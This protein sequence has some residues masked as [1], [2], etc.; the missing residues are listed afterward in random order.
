MYLK[1]RAY[2][3]VLLLAAFAANSQVPA[4]AGN[5]VPKTPPT[6]AIDFVTVDKNADGRLSKE[7]SAQV[8]DLGSVFATL[9]VDGDTYVTPAEFAKW[10]RA[11]N[12][13][14][15]R[16]PDPATAPSGSAGAQHMPKTE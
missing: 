10:D 16:R 12:A 13:D 15:V 5:A 7:E 9:D 14:T 1:N 6:P 3:A 2:P 4:P 11:G 8:A